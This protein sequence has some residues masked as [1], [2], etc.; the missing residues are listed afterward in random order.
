LA[1]LHKAIELLAHAGDAWKG[2][3]LGKL[4]DMLALVTRIDGMEDYVIFSAERAEDA[5]TAP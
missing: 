2:L 1:R 3:T 5:S 4:T